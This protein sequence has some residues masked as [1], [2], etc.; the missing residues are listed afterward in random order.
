MFFTSYAFA[1]DQFSMDTTPPPR[2]EITWIQLQNGIFDE[3][4]V[5]RNAN[6]PFNPGNIDDAWYVDTVLHAYFEGDLEGGN[7]NFLAE[8][9][10]ALRIRRRTEDGFTWVS[11]Y[12]KPVTDIDS[13]DFDF[14]DI[15]ARSNTTYE[16]S[17]VPISGGV[18]GDY[19]IR[20]ITT[21]FPGLFIMEPDKFYRT[22]LAPKINKQ[23]ER[24]CYSYWPPIPDCCVQRFD[25]L[26]QRVCVR[27]I[28]A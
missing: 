5:T 22:D 4:L 28:R 8:N 26:P 21:C 16:Y 13:F 27:N 23:T 19:I 14:L 1:A 3:L 11:L 15:T 7:M 24:S 12:E 20:Q 6:M 9:V 25:E 18:E 10:D 17:L 2:Q